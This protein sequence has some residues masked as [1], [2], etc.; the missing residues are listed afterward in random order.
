[1][2]R[3]YD[4]IH[5]RQTLYLELN[6]LRYICFIVNDIKVPLKETGM[7]IFMIDLGLHKIVSEAQPQGFINIIRLGVF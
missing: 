4:F 2:D 1:M 7:S 3:T 5:A 6:L